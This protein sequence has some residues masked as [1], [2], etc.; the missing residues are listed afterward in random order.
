M[1]DTDGCLEVRGEGDGGRDRQKGDRTAD[2]IEV[3]GI[4]NIQM[5][6]KAFLFVFAILLV[7][8]D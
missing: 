8:T 2:T 4:E 5:N 1:I 6:C 7:C 3:L